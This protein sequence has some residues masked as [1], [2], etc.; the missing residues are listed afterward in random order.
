MIKSAEE[1]RHHLHMNPEISFEEKET[2]KYLKNQIKALSKYYKKELKIYTPLETG[3]IVEYSYGEG[4]YVLYRADIDALEIKE[5][6]EYEYKSKNGKMHACGHDVHT[7]ILYGLLEYLLKNEIQ[8]NILLLFQPGEET[9]GGALKI[10]QTGILKKFSIERAHALHVTDE[11]EKGTLYT[12]DDIL[13]SSAM[14]V[15]IE[16]IGK[17]AHCAFP[18]DGI[19]AMEAMIDLIQK[20]KTIENPEKYIFAMGKLKSGNIRNVIPEKAK[21]EGTIRTKK[22]KNAE[23]IYKEIE[24]ILEE[25]KNEMKI[26]YKIEKGSFYKEV[27]NDEILYQKIIKKIPEIRKCDYKFTGED[28]GFISQEYPSIMFWLG[29]KIENHYGLHSPNF[30]PDD[31]NI[32]IGKNFL[33]KTLDI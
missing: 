23:I 32:E 26:D 10:L 19:N 1:I 7:S 22:S 15:N 12:N 25:I 2:T 11:Y 17:A 33:I 16:I 4:N 30:L 18:E 9:G 29:T 13:F 24:K 27:K 21:I 28:F 31:Q 3:L 14:E 6:T 8:K 5:T 20:S